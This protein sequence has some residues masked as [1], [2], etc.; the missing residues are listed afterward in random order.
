MG[1]IAWELIKIGLLENSR[2]GVVIFVCNSQGRCKSDNVEWEEDV[3]RIRSSTTE[4][5]DDLIIWSGAI[6]GAA[7]RCLLTND[8]QAHLCFIFV[9]NRQR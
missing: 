2:T 7:I 3:G 6:Q 5:C 8:S 9:P 1:I 4:N